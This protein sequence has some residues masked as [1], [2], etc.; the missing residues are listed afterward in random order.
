VE[1]GGKAVFASDMYSYGVLLYY[2]HFPNKFSNVVAGNIRI[3]SSTE[4]E[5]TDLLEKLL[6]VDLSLRPTANTALMHPYFRTTFAEKLLRD[7]EVVEQDR[8]LEAVRSMLHRCRNDNRSNIDNVVIRRNNLVGDVLAYFR[9]TPLERIKSNLRVS[10]VGEPGVDEGGLLTELFSMFY[11]LVFQGDGQLFEGSTDSN[12][13]IDA[14]AMVDN[15]DMLEDL[16]EDKVYSQYS[17]VVLPTSKGGENPTVLQN[18]RA[19]GRAMVKTLYEGRR[20][21]SRL[22]PS[23]F[24]F[25]TSTNPNMRDLQT[26]DRETARSLQWTLATIGVE[27]YGLHFES[28]NAPELGAVNDSNKTRFVSMKIQQILVDSRMNQLLSIKAGFTEAMK[29]LSEEAAPFLSLLSHADWRVLLCGETAVN[30]SQIISCLRFQGFPTKSSIPQWLKEIIMSS[31]DDHLR[32]FLVF[33]TGSPSIPST[34][35]S[36]LSSSSNI[37]ITVRCQPRSNALPIAHTCFFQLDIPDYRSKDILQ[38]KL[39]YAIQNTNTFEIV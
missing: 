6:S 31:S 18:L 1:A 12:K 22:C 20:I 7:G 2:M 33:M 15:L 14:S 29:A 34:Y 4:P 36:T 13:Q 32:Q 28:V 23:V 11:E 37:E 3:P 30:G 5:L 17:S 19:F 10:F 26:Y 16:E 27:E 39:I 21:G 38:S 8:K 25:I 35:S 24:K 9:D